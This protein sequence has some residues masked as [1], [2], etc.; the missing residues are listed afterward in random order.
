MSQAKYVNH[1]V[2][3]TIQFSAFAALATVLAAAL[4][5]CL[6]ALQPS[7]QANSDGLGMRPA[8]SSHPV[9][10]IHVDPAYNI[11]HAA[12]LYFTERGQS[13]LRG[14]IPSI[15]KENGIEPSSGKID[16]LEPVDLGTLPI[17]QPKKMPAQLR[18]YRPVLVAVRDFLKEWITGIALKD[19]HLEITAE[20]VTYLTRGLQIDIRA[21]AARTR[22]LQIQG[23]VLTA[24][25][26]LPSLEV[27]ADRIAARD[28]NNPFLGEVAVD[29]PSLS[30]PPQSPALKL[31]IPVQIEA[32]SKGQLR[33]NVL[34]D[35]VTSNLAELQFKLSHDPKIELP[36]V[37]LTINDQTSTLDLASARKLIRSK[38][39][40]VVKKLQK[41]LAESAG[42]LIQT[43]VASLSQDLL[44]AGYQDRIEITAPGQAPPGS[45]NA[46]T[47]PLMLGLRVSDVGL[48]DDHV[49]AELE[50]NV[51]D[52]QSA[53]IPNLHNGFVSRPAFNGLRPTDYDAALVLSQAVINRVMEL[54]FRRGNFRKFDIGSPGKPRYAKIVNAP[55]FV[56]GSDPFGRGLMHVTLEMTPEGIEQRIGLSSPFQI[57][58]DIQA[59]L[60]PFG[61]DSFEIVQDRI[62][63]S[64]A[65]IEDRYIT[66]GFLRKKVYEGI[67]EALNE[68]NQGY[69]KGQTLIADAT[70][71][72][73]GDLI[74][75]APLKIKKAEFDGNGYLVFYL[76]F[77][78]TRDPAS[79]PAPN[80][81]MRPGPKQ[82][83][84][85]F[86]NALGLYV[87]DRGL[88]YFQDDFQELLFR[89]GVDPTQGGYERL[90]YEAKE[91]VDLNHLPAHMEPYASTLG[92]L[93]DI[94][95]RW[96]KGFRFE[97]PRIAAQIDNIFYTAEF[98][99]L[100]FRLDK[101]ATAEFVAQG[102]HGAVIVFEATLPA[103]RIEAGPISAQDLNNPF[104]KTFGLAQFNFGIDAATSQPLQI[105]IPIEAGISPDEKIEFKMRD[106]VTN[107][108]QLTLSTGPERLAL[109]LPSIKIDINGQVATL[110][111]SRVE[112]ELLALKNQLLKPLQEYVDT[113]ARANVPN[114]INEIVASNYPSFLTSINEMDPPGAPDGARQPKYLWGVRPTSVQAKPDHLVFGL[115]AFV[116]DPHAPNPAAE[117]SRRLSTHEPKLNLVDPHKYDAAVV[118]N[119]DLINRILGLSY[120]RGY[121]STVE[122]EGSEPLKVLEAHEF[123]FDGSAGRDRGRL[124]VKLEHDAD[125]FAE[126]LAIRRRVSFE[127][128]LLARLVK[129]KDGNVM[130]QI[131]GVDVASLRMD[132]S[133]VRRIFRRRV[134]KSLQA[135]M[136]AL[137]AQFMRKPMP[138]VESLPIPS[139]IAG[140]PIRVS[141][142]QA[143]SNGY[144]VIYIEYE[145]SGS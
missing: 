14:H 101:K 119:Q 81:S 66:F 106:F 108:N 11:H 136:R 63:T 57:S 62:L 47:G 71:L 1:P 96:M 12:G 34:G 49:F 65:R 131:D 117:V 46:K 113:W 39:A 15:L 25:I 134:R 18:A 137:N 104:L 23:V 20:E 61:N 140:I 45:P 144:V 82:Q 6:V 43:K 124:H 5:V 88:R 74:D 42:Q 36:R 107:L 105:S 95:T 51:E 13:N 78:A 123:H 114:T 80:P 141:D 22:E 59:S 112:K 86:P 99:H 58:L 24:G 28:L 44:Q 53:V 129:T 102:G 56:D 33:I 109:T 54:A 133:D 73:T 68:L 9:A 31:M 83:S 67:Q 50:G 38:E 37:K 98:K 40:M 132:R 21:D 48:T 128:D 122:V 138:I 84:R 79:T 142:F 89:Q 92:E 76:D 94:I 2:K 4:F 90:K 52:P 93:R 16:T 85:S 121:L 70:P 7:A 127:M 130:V 75:G 72:S 103:L 100:G 87:T 77:V 110:N 116:E 111:N 32:A 19:P 27:R 143:D 125:G 91:G 97:D 29:H 55:Y 3:K 60:R 118:I 17:D 30:L 35:Q 8:P 120:Q 64:S 69:K 41:S 145:R 26:T 115:E 10:A 126:R 135:K 139:H